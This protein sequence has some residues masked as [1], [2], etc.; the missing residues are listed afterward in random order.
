MSNSDNTSSGCLAILGLLIYPVTWIGTGI[1]AW[2]W[3]DP[4]GFGG[5]LLFLIVWGIL[6]AIVQFIGTLIITGIASMME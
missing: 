5:A 3:V 6:G 4:S 2:N 1:M